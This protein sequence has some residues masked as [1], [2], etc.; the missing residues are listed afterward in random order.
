M[1]IFNTNR[2]FISETSSIAKNQ[3][4]GRELT[5][6]T[7]PLNKN[8]KYHSQNSCKIQSENR[9]TVKIGYS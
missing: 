6:N 9:R 1:V 8:K 3:I 5:K 4:Y 2:S 7:L